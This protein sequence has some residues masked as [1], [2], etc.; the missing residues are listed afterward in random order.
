MQRKFRQWVMEKWYE[1]KDECQA[2]KVPSEQDA[3][4]YFLKNRWF[5][6]AQ[7]RDEKEEND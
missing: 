4:E 7:Y 2:W 6:K 3:K 5:L 1:Y